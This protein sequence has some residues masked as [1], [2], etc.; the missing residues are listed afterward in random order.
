[1]S[2][3]SSMNVLISLSSFGAA[4]VGR[5]GQLWATELAMASGADGVEI[6]GELLHDAAVELPLLRGRAA[7]YSSPNGLWTADGL[8]DGV[9]LDL[10]IERAMA[11]QAPRLKMALG[12]FSSASHASLVELK[13]RLATQPVELV[14]ENDQ[15]PMAGTVHPLERFFAAQDA[16]GLDLGM[17]FD[18]GNWHWV[19]ECPLLA[20]KV[21][22]PRVRYI[23]CKGVQ[24]LPTKWVAVPLADSVAPWRAVLSALPNDVPHAIEYPLIGDD[25]VAATR[26]Q[27][28][29]IRSARGSE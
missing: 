2:A 3:L 27:L 10:G 28:A 16:A 4:E 13:A 22:A 25:L 17:T 9:A 11:L 20:A 29:H 18:M 1:M 24:R 6:R 15:S 12:G 5:H 19:G 7:V 14:I 26:A 23:H 21:F 8:L